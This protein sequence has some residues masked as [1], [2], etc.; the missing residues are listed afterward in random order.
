MYIPNRFMMTFCEAQ[1]LMRTY[2]FATVIAH[3]AG[4]LEASHLPVLYEASETSGA[5]DYGKIVGH[6]A[7]ANPLVDGLTDREVLIVFGG[8][9]AYISPNWYANHPAV[10]TWNYQAVHAYGT[11]RLITERDQLY[12]LVQTLST[13]HEST[14]PPRT[15]PTQKRWRLEDVD[16]KFLE[17]MLGAITGFEMPIARLEAKAKLSQNRADEDQAQVVKALRENPPT[18]LVGDAMSLAREVRERDA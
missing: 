14:L 3:V 7:S 12:A 15:D 9:H 11:P 18:I 10:P 16:E 2:G 8:P 1:D 4:T 5:G 6:L 13:Y 17:S